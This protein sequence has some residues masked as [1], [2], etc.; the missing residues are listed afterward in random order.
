[1]PAP[2]GEEAA[3]ADGKGYATCLRPG[4]GIDECWHQVLP[5]LQHSVGGSPPALIEAKK[6]ARWGCV[7]VVEFQP[8]FPQ[9]ALALPQG[10]VNGCADVAPGLPV[11]AAPR[12]G[13][14]KG[15][16]GSGMGGIQPVFPQT[17]LGDRWRQT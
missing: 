14:G 4:Q 11:L 16:V 13:K 9:H 2:A 10:S 1:M 7:G 8:G 12:F 15:E 3:V 5:R 17:N 6:D